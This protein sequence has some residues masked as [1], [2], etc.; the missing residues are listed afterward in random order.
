[1]DWMHKRSPW[2]SPADQEAMRRAMGQTLKM[3]RRMNLAEMTPQNDLASTRYCLADPGRE[4]L[5]YQPRSGETFT[6][7]LRAGIFQYE[8]LSTTEGPTGRTGRIEVSDG[9]C[10]FQPPFKGDAVLYLERVQ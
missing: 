3:A 8:W 6:V 10:Q 5:I 1:M 9:S 4:Y 2:Y 7:E